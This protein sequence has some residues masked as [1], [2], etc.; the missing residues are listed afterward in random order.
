MLAV[1]KQNYPIVDALLKAG[2]DPN[3]KNNKSKTALDIAEK[4][5]IKDLLS[6]ANQN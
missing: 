6:L 2:A 3:I 4:Q 5:E 1:A